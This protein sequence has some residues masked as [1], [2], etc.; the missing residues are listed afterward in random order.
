M[1]ER[2][3]ARQPS[4][5][6]T[7]NGLAFLRA[8]ATPETVHQSA[9]SYG[10]GTIGA[11]GK[12]TFHPA[13]HATKDAWQGGDQLPDRELGWVTLSAAGGH[14][15][16]NQHHAVVRRWTSPRTGKIQVRVRVSH[17]SDQGDGIR[18]RLA[19][20]ARGVVHEAVVQ[21]G[22]HRQTIEID[23]I[24]AGETL[25]FVIDCREH[26]SYDSFRCGFE[27]RFLD[28]AEPSRWD[29]EKDFRVSH[30]AG[31]RAWPR[32]AQILLLTNEFMF[33]D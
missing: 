6:E 20:A 26:P 31:L 28:G 14:P 8:E 9:W 32:Y 18:L 30:P 25:D 2:V 5:E 17:P 3:H 22:E 15:G 4:D 13:P 29:S 1:F 21:H 27:I 7:R 16:N 24:Q 19:S 12:V 33:V 10:F 23:S 11:E